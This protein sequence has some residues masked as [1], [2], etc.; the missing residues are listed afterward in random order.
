ME[1]QLT[2]TTD[3]LMVLCVLGV[4]IVLF[5]F[6]LLRV[7]VAAICIMVLLGLLNVVPAEHLFDGF[8]SNAVISII[9][10]M[11]LGAGLDRTGVMTIVA[12]FILRIGGRTESRIMP[13]VSATVGVISGFMQNVGATALFL[14]VVSRIATRSKIPLSRLLLPMG[15]C[16]IMGGTITMVG[17]S[18]LILLNDLIDNSNRNLPPGADTLASFGLFSTTPIGLALLFASIS[19]FL[20]LGRFMLPKGQT[21]EASTPGRTE[22][23]FAMTYG[24]E[25]EVYELLVTSESRLV[26]LNI[27]E[28]EALEN[29]PFI[30]AIRNGDDRHMAPG[31]EEMIWVGT[32]L[33]VMGPK[34]EIAEFAV[35]HDLVVHPRLQNFGTMF[36]PMRA[37]ISEV[38]ITNASTLVGKTLSEVQ[39]R[40]RYGLSVLALN[41]SGE[42]FR[43]RAR[44]MVL[45]VGDTLILH[46]VWRDLA[47]SSKQRD[48]VVVTDV[49]TEEHRPHKVGW[50]LFFFVISMGMIIFTDFRLSI[51][52]LLGAIGMV[53]T[54]VINIDEAYNAVSWKTVF[55]LASLIPLGLAMDTSGTAAWIAQEALA[56]LGDVPSWVLQV[57]L[58]VLT[59][60]F[61]LVMSNVGATALLVPLAINI[62]LATGSNPAVFALIVG[63]SASNSFLIPTHQVN[64][65]IMG[66]GGYKVID[67]LRSG[68]LVTVIFLAVSLLM[69]NL[70]Y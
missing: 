38:V 45:Q 4:T 51:S 24:V 18:P 33:G 50:A 10:V 2:L 41:R 62:A 69:I 42:T 70:L 26:G 52:L 35:A 39:F 32:I 37:G 29:P 44:E 40:R 19:Y 12:S 61:T 56:V 63:I 64:A 22:N 66:P 67:F 30:L 21:M 65:L 6:E 34:E 59:T 8:A 14:P 5:V 53:V 16:A 13:M 7:D 46:S 36:N 9:A 48:F 60:F 58:A 55:L 28:A 49:P 27:G 54:G 20:L 43:S 15:F 68:G 3:M 31:S 57:L 47:D 23:Y 25:G 17:S 11:I 1:A